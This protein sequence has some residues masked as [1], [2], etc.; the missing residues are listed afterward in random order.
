MSHHNGAEKVWMVL[1]DPTDGL[2]GRLGRRAAVT[3]Q[4]DSQ[5]TGKLIQDFF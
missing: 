1:F 4:L 5:K 3:H 2:S